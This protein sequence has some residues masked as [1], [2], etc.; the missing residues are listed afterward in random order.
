[1]DISTLVEGNPVNYQGVLHD[2]PLAHKMSFAPS[3]NEW[4]KTIQFSKYPMANGGVKGYAKTYDAKPMVDVPC[5]PFGPV[6]ED[7]FSF[8]GKRINF[9]SLDVEGSE[10]LVLG[11]ID[12]SR[13]QIDVLMIE[14][15]NSHCKKNSRCEVRQ[16]VREKMASEGYQ[17][18]SGLVPKSD[19]YIHPYSPFHVPED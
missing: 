9:F 1:M 13:V 4:N 8:A 6:L 11:T 3:C 5:G 15:Q 12:F 16:Q 19:I 7:I 17:M 18:Y 10:M 2:R 14:V